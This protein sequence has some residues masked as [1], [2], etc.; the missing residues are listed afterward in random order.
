LRL[1]LIIVIH[2]IKLDARISTASARD[3]RGA[4]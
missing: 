1:Y 2:Y 3:K 4:A